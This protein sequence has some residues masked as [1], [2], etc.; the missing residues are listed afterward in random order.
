M[1]DI[2]Y[3]NNSKSAFSPQTTATVRSL[4]AVLNITESISALKQSQKYMPIFI[5]L[6]ANNSKSALVHTNSD[7]E[8]ADGL[9][10]YHRIHFGT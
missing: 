4:T 5:V 6:C 3:A 7:S 1:E 2:N 9:F 10:K 8:I